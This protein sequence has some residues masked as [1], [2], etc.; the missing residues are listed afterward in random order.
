MIID[1]AKFVAAL[2][3]LGVTGVLAGGISIYFMKENRSLGIEEPRV[4][5]TWEEYQEVIRVYN[6]KI[7]DIKADC[8]NDTRCDKDKVIFRGARTK[9]DVINTLNDWIE[10]DHKDINTYKLKSIEK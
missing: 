9:E 5:I 3:T 8:K 7:A 1:K 2:V 4:Y 6:V 10:N